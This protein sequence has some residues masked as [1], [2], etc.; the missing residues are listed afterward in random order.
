MWGAQL[1]V[2]G[3]AAFTCKTL[4]RLLGQDPWA[5]AG[6]SRAKATKVWIIQGTTCACAVANGD[7]ERPNTA[8]APRAAALRML[9][10][11]YRL[12]QMRIHSLNFRISIPRQQILN[13]GDCSMI[14]SVDHLL[15][16][17]AEPR[18]KK[19]HVSV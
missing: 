5:P 1:R 11:G 17:P 14:D 15:S 8:D 16:L 19:G 3:R 18:A 10:F 7:Y 6:F 4:G 2:V 12:I 9:A 13:H